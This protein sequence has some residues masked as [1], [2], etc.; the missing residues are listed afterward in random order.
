MQDDLALDLTAF[1][2]CSWTDAPKGIYAPVA[3]TL[4]QLV[5]YASSFA[6]G[7]GTFSGSIARAPNGVTLTNSGT[8]FTGF[9]S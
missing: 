1:D 6:L 8:T 2:H 3:S 4:G 7:T 9:Q 5:L